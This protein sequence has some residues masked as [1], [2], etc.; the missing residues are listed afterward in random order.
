MVRT[1]VGWLTEDK[2]FFSA[3][4]RETSLGQEIW[5]LRRRGEAISV[6]GGG[7]V[8]EA[9]KIEGLD[10][11]ANFVALFTG[12]SWSNQDEGCLVV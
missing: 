6:V 3:R 1:V 9:K 8:K 11:G 10:A 2:P 12:N 5:R 7:H 4:G